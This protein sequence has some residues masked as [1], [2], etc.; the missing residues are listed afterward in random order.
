MTGP[1]GE[2]YHGWWRVTSVNPPK[3]LEFRDGFA[4]Q[5]GT[6]TADMPT[7]TVHMQL[8]E[9]GSGTRM[10]LRT[11]FDSREEMERLDGMG[12]TE[13]MREAVGQMDALLAG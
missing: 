13:G 6:P 9:Q 11:V 1:E 4:D 10:E 8:T 12:M 3:S 7:T 2:K 5:E